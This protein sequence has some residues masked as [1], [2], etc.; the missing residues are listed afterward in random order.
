MHN[1]DAAV[2]QTIG[3]LVGTGTI[4]NTGLAT[5]SSLAVTGEIVPGGPDGGFVMIVR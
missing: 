1:N 2:A 3:N 5:G 4:A